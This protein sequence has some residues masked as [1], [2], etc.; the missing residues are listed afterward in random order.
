MNF[1]EKLAIPEPRGEAEKKAYR[2]TLLGPRRNAAVFH[3][4]VIAIEK[5]A[6]PERG[7]A[8]THVLVAVPSLREREKTQRQTEDRMQAHD[9]Q[10]AIGNAVLRYLVKILVK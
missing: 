5:L 9:R 4:F 1:F 2:H 7:E 8:E 3:D 10:E 6:I